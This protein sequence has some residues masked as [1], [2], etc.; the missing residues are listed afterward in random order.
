MFRDGRNPRSECINQ[1]K[2]RSE[3][4]EYR[5]QP[6]RIIQWFEHAA[7]LEQIPALK[8]DEKLTVLECTT[9]FSTPEALLKIDNPLHDVR[10]QQVPAFDLI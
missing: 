2:Y 6:T 4:I 5:S 9:E 3:I 8:R 10:R 1:A 7:G